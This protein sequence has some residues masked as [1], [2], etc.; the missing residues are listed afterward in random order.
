MILGVECLYWNP[1]STEKYVL[2]HHQKSLKKFLLSPLPNKS[3]KVKVLGFV[4]LKMHY[5]VWYK[6]K[7]FPWDVCLKQAIKKAGKETMRVMTE[8]V[9][10]LLVVQNS[11]L[12][13]QETLDFP[14]GLWTGDR[15]P[16]PRWSSSWSYHWSFSFFS[17]L[18]T[19]S[20][21]R[22]RILQV[23]E[24]PSTLWSW[25][26]PIFPPVNIPTF[27]CTAQQHQ[28]AEPSV[29]P[30]RNTFLLET[31]I[32]FIQRKELNPPHGSLSSCWPWGFTVDFKKRLNATALKYSA[33]IM[34]ETG[35]EFIPVAAWGDS[36]PQT[37]GRT[38]SGSLF[39][40][41]Q[42]DGK[43]IK[44]F[45]ASKSGFC[46]LLA[47]SPLNWALCTRRICQKPQEWHRVF[48]S[49]LGKQQ[50]SFLD[51]NGL[52]KNNEWTDG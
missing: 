25:F 11:A 43:E 21:D 15:M 27:P 13:L 37:A 47:M 52:C 29:C 3:N 51:L 7:R 17:D 18:F 12:E 30:A 35:N 39:S 6:G 24:V 45:T 5:L 41:L 9:Q 44:T 48:L 26:I 10:F 32:C 23:R 33:A 28:Q 49:V 20:G 40:L 42:I 16:S 46:S 8:F 36:V 1:S 31:W 4:H 14:S 34:R 38:N 22:D 2:V 50:N 19:A